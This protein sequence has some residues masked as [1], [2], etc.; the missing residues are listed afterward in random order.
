MIKGDEEEGGFGNDWYFE[1]RSKVSRSE[2][3]GS[4]QISLEDAVL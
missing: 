3:G 2:N 1:W 4:G